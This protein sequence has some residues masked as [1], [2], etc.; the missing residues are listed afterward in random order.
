MRE[1]LDVWLP[2]RAT[3]L[4]FGRRL[5]QLEVVEYPRR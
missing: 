5:V 1:K 2:D 3:A 4:R